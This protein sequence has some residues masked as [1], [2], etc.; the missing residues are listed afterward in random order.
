MDL[1]LNSFFFSLSGK[2]NRRQQ[3]QQQENH[4]DF[5]FY[6]SYQEKKS[7]ARDRVQVPHRRK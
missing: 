7:H 3:Q 2:Q 4:A 5:Q 1:L 6:L